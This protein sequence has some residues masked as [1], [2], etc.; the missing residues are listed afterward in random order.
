MVDMYTAGV[1]VAAN[2]VGLSAK[3]SEALTKVLSGAAGE[4]ITRLPIAS[5]LGAGSGYVIGK[6][7]GSEHPERQAAA[8]AVVPLVETTGTLLA[9]PLRKQLIQALSR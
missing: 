2:T 4:H 8:G 1:K 5:L 9:I 3:L 7:L 6:T